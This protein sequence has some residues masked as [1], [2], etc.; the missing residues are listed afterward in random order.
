MDVKMWL[1]KSIK[2]WW[3]DQKVTF[4]F[5]VMS[6]S[7]WNMWD[8]N[9]IF[10]RLLEAQWADYEAKL[11]HIKTPN[12][13]TV[14]TNTT[15]MVLV[16]S[17]FMHIFL[18]VCVWVY[19]LFLLGQLN[20]SLVIWHLFL[21]FFCLSL[22]SFY[23]SFVASPLDY[24]CHQVVVL[25]VFV[26]NICTYLD[27]QVNLQRKESVCRRERAFTPG[28]STGNVAKRGGNQGKDDKTL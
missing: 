2:S 11:Y 25:C 13:N 9:S 4:T 16:A 22:Q 14:T 26:A 21:L 12:W 24:M 10:H 3:H 5:T 7:R 15:N 28:W 19:R 17:D 8:V 20:L 1:W 27:I 18:F 23:A 6:S